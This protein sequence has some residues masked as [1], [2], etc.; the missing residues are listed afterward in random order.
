MNC[1]LDESSFHHI[2][3]LEK[4]DER[5][6]EAEICLLEI[7]RQLKQKSSRL[8]LQR[9][10]HFQGFHKVIIIPHNVHV[11]VTLS[12]SHLHYH[13]IL[14]LLFQKFPRNVFPYHSGL[15][16]LKFLKNSLFCQFHGGCSHLG[17]LCAV[18]LR[19]ANREMTIK[20]ICF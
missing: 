15:K 14:I 2:L 4:L 10:S 18:E 19:S 3:C 7:C 13:I 12:N 8:L 1:L 20:G 6:F 16:T 17:K 9:H 5:F 11:F